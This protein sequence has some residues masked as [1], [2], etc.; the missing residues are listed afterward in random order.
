M[1][2]LYG[3][4][5]NVTPGHLPDVGG[6][7]DNSA[8]CDDRYMKMRAGNAIKAVVISMGFFVGPSCSS[9]RRL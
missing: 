8:D 3:E 7:D 2:L 9:V 5:Q 6:A 4:V 1:N